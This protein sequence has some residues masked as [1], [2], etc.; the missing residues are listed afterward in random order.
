MLLSAAG[1]IEISQIVDPLL[2]AR[3]VIPQ[4][5]LDAYDITPFKS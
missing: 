2:T 1:D 4:Y 5:V 3:F